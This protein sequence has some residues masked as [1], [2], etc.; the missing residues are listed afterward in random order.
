MTAVEPVEL[1]RTKRPEKKPKFT[2]KVEPPKDVK[3][4]AQFQNQ[5]G[6]TCGPPLNL[7]VD[8]NPEQLALL[9]NKLLEN[10]IRI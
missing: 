1:T 5:D 8:I 2:P 6:E 3:V 9:L 4:I 7:P 10:V